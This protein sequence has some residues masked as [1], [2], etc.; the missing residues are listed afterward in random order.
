MLRAL[1][2]YLL[3]DFSVSHGFPFD[4]YYI[5]DCVTSLYFGKTPGQ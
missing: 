3:S 2:A 5:L 1:A 4:L